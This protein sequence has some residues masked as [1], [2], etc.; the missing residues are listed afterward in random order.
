MNYQELAQKVINNH[1][2][3]FEEALSIIK[4]PDKEI[5]SL[6][7]GSNALREE[8]K[9]NKIKLCAIKNAKSGRCS[10]NCSFCA[11]SAHHKT[12]TDIYPL[13][14]EQ[15][16]V[17][18]AK[19]AE[20][21][22]SAGCFSIVTSGKTVHSDEDLETIA[23]AVKKIA[24]D[25]DL[26]RCVSLGTLSKEQLTKLK[27]AGLKRLHHNLETAKSF[28]KNVCST[29]TYVER[30]A[31]IM[32]AKEAGL[33]V[34]CGGI[35]GLGESEEQR[36]EF[37]FELKALGVESVPLNILNPVAGT[38]AAQNYA[39]MRPLEIL[40]LIAAYRFVL[41]KQDIGILGGREVNLKQLQPLIFAAGANVILIGNYL[42][43][44]G[45]SPG[46]DLEMI[47][48]LGL[49]IGVGSWENNISV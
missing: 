15:E 8:Y 25:T 40:K 14:S 2:I 41:P 45:Q 5:Y 24:A 26:N 10:E 33:E 46:K 19:D 29:H 34:C 17:T 39:P 48:D 47:R 16:I 23:R 9:G 11:Q 32:A 37:A 22:M 35:F 42:T 7:S 21:E 30:V 4:T 38:P 44:K 28:F 1:P 18:Y 20:K 36:I 27:S 49:E 13:A 12:S 31:T 3:S 6:L 43:T